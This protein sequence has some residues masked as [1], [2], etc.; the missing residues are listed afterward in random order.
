MKFDVSAAR[1]CAALVL[2]VAALGLLAVKPALAQTPPQATTAFV[3]VNVVPMDSDRV[4]R[5]QTVI[6]RDG[7][8][9]A[10]GHAL[11]VPADAKVIDGHGA[12][13]LSP[14]LADMHTHSDTKQ[15]MAVYLANGVTTVLNMGGAK[16]G[17]VDLTIPAIDEG[18][19]PGPRVYIGFLVDGSPQYANF[20]VKTPDEA[21]ALVRLLKTNRY[22]FIKVYNDLSPECFYALVDEG[23]KLGI[24]TIGHGVTSVGLEK[25]IDAGQVM[26]AHTEEFL[27]TV[28]HYSDR[29]EPSPAQV[30]AAIDFVKR[31]HAYVTA[32][33]VT[34]TTIAKQWGKASATAVPAYLDRQDVRYLSPDRRVS[35]RSASYAT[36]EG[37]ITPNLA[38]LTRFTKDM[39]DAGVPLITG[40]DAP[41]IAGLAP[42][43]SLHDDLDVLEAAGL[44]RFQVLSAATRTPGEF[45]VRNL[46]GAEPF[47]VVAPGDRADLVLT[48]ANPLEGLAT[49][50]KPLG[51]MAHGRWY[52][53]SDL[54]A[55]LAGVASAYDQ[56]SVHH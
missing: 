3:S 2:G 46:A 1:L 16:A 43:F 20:V 26:V 50:R 49:L 10:I 9:E 40:T 19:L 28:F 54:E 17:F 55:L 15:D 13:Y 31:N 6:V 37:D 11:P 56:A 35:W 7:K 27:Y 12:A 24:P 4:L 5:D 44:T 48:E 22:D 53:R 23:K 33:L 45:I 42:G 25:Q 51:V 38:F 47:G 41:T 21:R 30:Q 32:D 14:G 34:Y 8:I 18:K 36:R 39:S 52:A 29:G